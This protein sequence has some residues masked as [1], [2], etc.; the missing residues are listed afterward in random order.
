MA[1]RL[2]R[3]FQ[4]RVFQQTQRR[5]QRRRQDAN[6]CYPSCR[7]RSNQAYRSYL[8]IPSSFWRVG[9][10]Q[11]SP[12]L[13]TPSRL[14]K[15]VSFAEDTATAPSFSAPALRRTRNPSPPRRGGF[16]SAPWCVRATQQAA[17]L[18][19]P[20]LANASVLVA[21]PRPRCP[22]LARTSSARRATDTR[23]RA[24]RPRVASAATPRRL[25]RKARW[26]CPRLFWRCP[27]DPGGSSA[28]SSSGSLLEEQTRGLWSARSR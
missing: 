20:P 17:R 19:R 18:H 12:R 5:S 15:R 4:S 11:G 28:S 2:A 9:R 6:T 10:N 3:T 24:R 23:W 25:N 16:R 13:S 1:V 27:E 26:G 7:F 8:V 21:A 14:T 22:R